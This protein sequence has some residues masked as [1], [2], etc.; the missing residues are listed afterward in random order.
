MFFVFLGKEILVYNLSQKFPVAL[1][2]STRVGKGACILLPQGTFDN[3]WG[4]FG[5]EGGQLAPEGGGRGC[6]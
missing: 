1:W 5:G 3:V 2:F 4:P 6:C